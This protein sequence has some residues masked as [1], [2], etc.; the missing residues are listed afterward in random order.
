MTKKKIVTFSGVGLHNG[1]SV[2]LT[3]Q[4]SE[5]DTGIIFKRVDLKTDNLLYPNVYLSLVYFI[6]RRLKRILAY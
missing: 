6:I 4:P 5:P 1:K 2:N 3:L